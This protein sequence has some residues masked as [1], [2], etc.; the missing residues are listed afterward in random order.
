MSPEAKEV[1]N[2]IAIEFNPEIDPDLKEYSETSLQEASKLFTHSS[3]K[4][5]ADSRLY[6]RDSHSKYES[7]ENDPLTALGE[8]KEI[9]NKISEGNMAEELQF[10]RAT[11]SY[12]CAVLLRDFKGKLGK[13]ELEFCKDVIF[14][15]AKIVN[16]DD[17]M[18]QIGDGIVPAL[19]VLPK[20]IEDFPDER[21]NIKIILIRA[22]M[23]HDSISIMGVDRINSVV[24]Q[25]VQYLWKDEPKF[26]MSL[27]IGYLV[28]SQK[29]RDVKDRLRKD[30]YKQH[31]HE[32]DKNDF[33]QK[34]FKELEGVV[35]KL[36]DET[37]TESVI[38]NVDSIDNDILITAFQLVP[39]DSGYMEP[40]PF[41]EEIIKIISQQLLSA[42]REER[43]DYTLK[44]EFL[45]HFSRFVLHLDNDEKDK[46]LKYFTDGFTLNEGMADLLN[47]F[48]SAE[49]SL[50]MPDSFWYVWN[51]FKDH[52]VD[53][54]SRQGWRHDKERIIESFLFAR[55]PWKE[56]AMTW[57]TF[58]P[59][60]K[61]FL[62]I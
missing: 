10:V 33:E 18:H 9:W 3:L 61:E 30:A 39:L 31:K 25:A 34:L 49:D 48:V 54:I 52:I 19:F 45:K 60:N 41:I 12:V 53:S 8:A 21:F 29:Y 35:K 26:M 55:V 17:Y 15:Y 7:Y 20:L 23:R 57:H 4:I 44:Y 62:E 14:K 40:V 32:I 59:K 28:I 43:L 5:W 47:E 42:N 2:G 1:E 11:P 6:N 56:G 46:Y 36:E 37:I 13:S 50:N 27:Y 38:D 24:I 58:S 22:L 16:H 51:Q